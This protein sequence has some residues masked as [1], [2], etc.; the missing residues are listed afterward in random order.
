M[1][2]TTKSAIGNWS[3][4]L[5]IIA[6]A[7]S[8]AIWIQVQLSDRPT[9]AEAQEMID[10][11]LGEV[12]IRLRHQQELLLDQKDDLDEINSKLDELR[13]R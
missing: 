13:D 3:I 4:V 6:T 7:V 12:D 9:R 8:V 2:D 1:T 5:G 10:R 11:S